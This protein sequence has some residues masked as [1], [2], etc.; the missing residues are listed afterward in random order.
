M[1]LMVVDIEEQIGTSPTETHVDQAS[2]EAAAVAS[3]SHYDPPGKEHI[4]V[5]VCML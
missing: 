4:H 5:H 2:N 3:T 1:P